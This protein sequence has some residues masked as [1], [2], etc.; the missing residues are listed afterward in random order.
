MT[1][2]GNFIS[3]V[4]IAARAC[5]GS[6]AYLCA[7]G[8][9]YIC[10]VAMA[11]SRNNFL[12]GDNSVAYTAVRA[13]GKTGLCATRSNCRVNNGGVISGRNSFLCLEYCSTNVTMRA[14]CETC[15]G[16]CGSNRSVYYRCVFF[17][18]TIFNAANRTCRFCSTCCSSACVNVIYPLCIKGDFGINFVVFKIPRIGEF[19]IGKPTVE[20]IISLG[21]I[22]R[23][24]DKTA[25]RNR[26]GSYGVSTVSLEG[27]GIL[28]WWIR[29]KE[30]VA[31]RKRQY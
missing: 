27:Y 24:C 31:S 19:C 28:V 6:I 1:E 14:F 11:K 20:D 21:G 29:L 5:V 12:S 4:S 22:F 18:Y 17:C 30:L 25:S 13:L 23:S 16:T 26:Q 10:L 15:G 8:S 3:G 2:R 9:C 7:G